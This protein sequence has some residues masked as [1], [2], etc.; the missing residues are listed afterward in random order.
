M[1]DNLPTS[2]NMVKRGMVVNSYCKLCGERGEDGLHLFYR[3]SF[4]VE[5]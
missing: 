3:C 1:T 4:T 5:I 2:S